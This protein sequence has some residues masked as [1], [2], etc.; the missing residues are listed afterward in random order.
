VGSDHLGTWL[1]SHE[2][3]KNLLT[4]IEPKTSGLLD[5]LRSRSDN[6]PLIGPNLAYFFLQ[7]SVG[8]TNSV[9]PR[10]AY[11]ST[12]SDAAIATKTVKM[13][14]MNSTVVSFIL[15]IIYVDVSTLSLFACALTCLSANWLLKFDFRFC[16][17]NN[18]RRILSWDL[19]MGPMIN[20][21]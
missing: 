1:E 11:V 16:S 2:I 12:P 13:A 5:Q 7:T 9:A 3:T 14:P 4:G 18:R 6:Q 19:Q 21:R 20:Y 10:K 8:T 17:L 15:T